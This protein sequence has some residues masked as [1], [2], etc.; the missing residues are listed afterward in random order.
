MT[1]GDPLRAQAVAILCR[2]SALLDEGLI[3]SLLDDPVDEVLEEFL[4][5]GSHVYSHESFHR[6][7]AA[8][9]HR[10]HD[11]V[12]HCG[13]QVTPAQAHEEA[14]AIL[15]RTYR[16][17]DGGGCDAAA[18]DAADPGGPGI[19]L[20]L[21]SL[22]EAVKA[23]ERS[24]YRAWVFGR[25]VDTADWPTKCAMARLLLGGWQDELPSNLRQ[26]PPEFWA[27]DIPKL[28]RTESSVPRQRSQL[29][30]VA[31]SSLD[32]QSIVVAARQHS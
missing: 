10:L 3:A 17:A 32:F 21:A 25:H 6:T 1:D 11:R 2:V 4:S 19:P 16:G 13:C 31:S 26:F 27:D 28:L 5:M 22:A 24:K 9:L 29:I 30:A 15:E 14:V 23:L 12:L 7:L 20:V 8:F 18:A